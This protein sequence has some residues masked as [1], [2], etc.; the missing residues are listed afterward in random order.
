MIQ[1]WND[2]DV[3]DSYDVIAERRPVELPESGAGALLGWVVGPGHCV[4]VRQGRVEKVTRLSVE[5]ARAGTRKA[6]EEPRSD[7]DWAL[8]SEAIDEYLQEAGVPP[9]PGRLTWYLV[10]TR[11]D[12]DQSLR[13]LVAA[14][15]GSADPREVLD[16][17]RHAVPTRVTD[18]A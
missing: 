13:D 8:L 6:W 1:T 3:V 7:D 5:D 4:G 16:T 15:V 18:P 12:D 17:M 2:F 9:R 14:M 11:V 10:D